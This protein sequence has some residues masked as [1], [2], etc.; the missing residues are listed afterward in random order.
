MPRTRAPSSTFPAFR[1]TWV[2]SHPGALA[3]KVSAASGPWP[4]GLSGESVRKAGISVI[5]ARSA[6]NMEL[7]DMTPS[8]ERP[9]KSVPVKEK[10][11]MAA[12]T[13]QSVRALPTP[14]AASLSAEA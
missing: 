10:K 8:S 11:P 6:M 1:R 3:A 7:P 4:A 5:L 12:A 13:A 2:S 14:A 9:T